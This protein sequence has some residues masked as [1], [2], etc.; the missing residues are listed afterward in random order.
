M[1]MLTREEIYERDG[2][3]CVYCGFDG[4]TFEGWR[5][6]TLDHFKPLSKGGTYERDNLVTACVA[7]NNQKWNTLFENL[8]AAKAAMR[9]ELQ[10]EVRRYWEQNVGHRVSKK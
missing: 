5:F 2:F 1:P 9:K 4:S 10:G 8:E 3:R 6:L 7:C